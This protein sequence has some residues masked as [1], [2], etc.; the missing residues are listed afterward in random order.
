L[1]FAQSREDPQ[2]TQRSFW[3]P[4]RPARRAPVAIE[5]ARARWTRPSIIARWPIVPA[6]AIEIR[7]TLLFFASLAAFFSEHRLT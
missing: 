2:K 4:S 6:V 3:S 1:C 5:A 7:L